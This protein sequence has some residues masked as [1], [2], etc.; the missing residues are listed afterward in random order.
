MVYSFS[1]KRQV[2]EIALR[3]VLLD[4]GD[5]RGRP[6]LIERNDLARC[7]ERIEQIGDAREAIETGRFRRHFRRQ[8]REVVLNRNG[9]HVHLNV[10]VLFVEVRD[11]NGIRGAEAGARGWS[12]GKLSCVA[13]D[14]A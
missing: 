14:A 8:L 7:S 11:Q 6:Y 5:L 13:A 10:G 4:I 3:H 9:V 12:V 1:L 2:I